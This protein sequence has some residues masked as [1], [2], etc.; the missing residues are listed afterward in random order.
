MES[1]TTELVAQGGERLVVP[2]FD[3]RLTLNSG[4]VF[5]AEEPE[6]GIFRVLVGRR[7]LAAR[8]NGRGLAVESGAL[9]D[10]VD[11]LALDHPMEEILASFPDDEYTRQAMGSA[12][13]MRILRQPKWEC[14]ATFITSSMKQVAHIRQMSLRIR[15]CW[16]E[17]VEESGVAAY[18]DAAVLAGA[19]EA[20]LRKCSLGYRARHLLG[21]ARFVADGEIDLEGI[22]VLSTDALLRELC[23]IPGVGRKVANCV[24]LFAYGRLGVVPVDVWVARIARALRK[25]NGTP[26]ELERYSTRKFGPYAGYVQQYLFHHARSTGKLPD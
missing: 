17:R 19:D 21:A 10:F 23:R 14:L 3:L 22:S 4:Q 18:P 1:S 13:G 8:V 11:Y 9:G 2:H 7:L 20:A 15:E 26:L 5:H 6:S 12:R 25:R 16:G 24:A